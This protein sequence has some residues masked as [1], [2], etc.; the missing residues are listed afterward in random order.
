MAWNS[1]V[2]FSWVLFSAKSINLKKKGQMHPA[3]S[4][5]YS[6]YTKKNHL[7][8][9][10]LCTK[11]ISYF[12]LIYSTLLNSHILVFFLKSSWHLPEWVLR[13]PVRATFCL[14]LVNFSPDL[15]L[16]DP[17]YFFPISLSV[18]FS[19]SLPPSMPHEMHA[20]SRQIFVLL[21]LVS[22]LPWT[23]LGTQKMFN[24]LFARWIYSASN[25][26]QYYAIYYRKYYT[27]QNSHTS[28]K[29][30]KVPISSPP[31]THL[32]KRQD[33]RE[34]DVHPLYSVWQLN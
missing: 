27:E 16:S 26:G 21:H 30:M 7:P 11:A 33:P 32:N 31:H 24:R 13:C 6:M 9:S 23:A 4:V 2:E 3:K 20:P 1:S 28:L 22:L 15:S 12:E 5:N 17:F 29:S 25:I 18:S 14:T 8:H 10:Q 34:W 19:V